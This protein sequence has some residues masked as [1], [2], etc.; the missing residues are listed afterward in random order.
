LN[1]QQVA[2][3][4]SRL[5][6]YAP[7]PAADL[8]LDFGQRSTTAKG[9]RSGD[10]PFKG[11][12]DDVRVYNRGMNATE[13]VDLYEELSVPPPPAPPPAALLAYF[14]LDDGQF[15]DV[16]NNTINTLNL[17][18]ATIP[19]RVGDADGALEFNATSES[20]VDLGIVDYSPAYNAGSSW[21][22][23]MWVKARPDGAANGTVISKSDAFSGWRVLLD[24]TANNVVKFYTNDG[25][26]EH[27]LT[28]TKR[29]QGSNWHHVVVE[30]DGG[31]KRVYFDGVLDQSASGVGTPRIN[32]Q[33]LIFG[34]KER[35]GSDR[36]GYDGW[37]DEVR[38]YNKA[39]GATGVADLYKAQK[40]GNY[41]SALIKVNL[42]D[43]FL[44]AG[45]IARLELFREAGT[46][47]KPFVTKEFT[48]TGDAF[49]YG[50]TFAETA[51][52]WLDGQGAWKVTNV[53]GNFIVDSVEITITTAQYV[54]Y[55]KYY[56]DQMPASTIYGFNAM[57]NRD[58]FFAAV[59]K[60]SQMTANYTLLHEIGHLLSASH[61]L[62]DDPGVNLSSSSHTFSPYKTQFKSA[63]DSFI[64]MGN[65]FI[66]VS[67]NGTRNFGYGKYCTIMA[68]PVGG[69]GERRIPRFSGAK[70]TWGGMSTGY[71]PG[72]FLPPPYGNF[73]VPMPFDNAKALTIIGNV[74]SAYR[75]S[76][77]TLPTDP[78]ATQ[79]FRLPGMREGIADQGGAQQ[80]AGG[81]GGRTGGLP[82]GSGGSSGS[83]SSNN[84]PDATGGN[85][86]R[87]E[88]G[89]GLEN[90]GRPTNPAP[91]RP[92]SGTTQR[93]PL[94]PQP[95]GN[96]GGGRRPSGRPII[97]RPPNPNPK[98]VTP[99]TLPNDNP[100][101]AIVLAPK[102]QIDGGYQATA[103]GTNRGATGSS[104]ENSART[105]DNRRAFH[106]KSVWWVLQAPAAGTYEIIADTAG[107][108]IDTTLSVYL[109]GN[110][111]PRSN[112]NAPNS[113]A[114]FSRVQ[115]PRV[116]IK[117]GDSIRIAVDGVN[118]AEGL[119]KLRIRL[120]PIR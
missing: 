30:L 77:G 101:G 114:P 11:M 5:T 105:D 60:H 58:V 21:A 48:A 10:F 22:L 51:N 16:V 88:P 25:S 90:T 99:S 62:G 27:V 92:D 64:S 20:L 83:P 56:I 37:L 118:G 98:P 40:P 120:K 39:L 53:K 112:D 33:Q 103:S 41:G 84:P 43:D 31:E 91:T 113:P 7:D 73:N 26:V 89:R 93:P 104:N 87:R 15:S 95:G 68:T 76:D 57:M 13:V 2:V 46:T 49:T 71:Q 19:G 35:V 63:Q 12:M 80:M 29:V 17:G 1:G 45:E 8:R 61:G 110:T 94:Q 100:G 3:A 108:N 54:R 47:L 85:T 106:G 38:I 32:L 52:A 109:P 36:E 24:E 82:G 70:S 96:N 79:P 65:H 119:I 55:K 67:G 75:D 66:S 86:G 69:M 59:V 34:A 4:K 115:I 9:G 111:T 18:V 44:D 97:V 28:G 81:G 42:K 23:S 74:A 72:V 117:A 6:I 14:P 50:F 102:R 78:N 107:S 116:A